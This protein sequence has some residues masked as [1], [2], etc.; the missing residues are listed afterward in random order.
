M[1]KTRELS[2]FDRWG[3]LVYYTNALE[4]TDQGLV[5]LRVDEGKEANLGVYVFMQG[6]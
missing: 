3:G 4:R 6:C 2:I 5:S 1:W